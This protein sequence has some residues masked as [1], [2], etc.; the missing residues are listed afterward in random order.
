MYLDM[1][2]ND[3]LRSLVQCAADPSPTMQLH[4]QH[5]VMVLKSALR[6]EEK[7]M[8]K[9]ITKNVLK[10]I[11][12]QLENNGAINEIESLRKAIEQLVK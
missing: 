11:S 7:A 6:Q 12:V 3:F 1:L 8:E 10:A 2:L 9:R 5:R 4:L